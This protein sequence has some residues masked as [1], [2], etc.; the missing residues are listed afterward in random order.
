MM[1]YKPNFYKTLL[2]SATIKMI[3][4]KIKEP[5]LFLLIWVEITKVTE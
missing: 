1:G 3:Y 5:H 2:M 4:F